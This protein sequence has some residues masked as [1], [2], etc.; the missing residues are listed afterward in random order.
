MNEFILG[1]SQKRG[2]NL[3]LIGM[4]GSGKSTLGALL[5]RRLGMTLLDTD[6]VIKDREKKSLQD[7]LD[8][9][10]VR[11]F[12]QKEAAAIQSIQPQNCV[13]ATGGSV[14]LDYDAMRY[15]RTLGR[16]VYLDV[17]LFKLER[18]LWNIKTRGIVIK[19]GQTIRD[20]FRLRKP[21]YEKYADYIQTTTHLSAEQ[22]VD[23]IASWWQSTVT[24]N[25][26]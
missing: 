16:I 12:I 8:Q 3:I 10:G 17:P 7:L 15:L 19:Q 23:Q 14:V 18:R 25:K 1:S 24:A 13:I 20:I 22:I 2:N 9:Y 11:T 5:A 4:P 21:L 6:Q 26:V